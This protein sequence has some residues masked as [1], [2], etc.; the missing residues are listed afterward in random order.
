MGIADDTSLP[1]KKDTGEDKRENDGNI[2]LALLPVWGCV[3]K[4]MDGDSIWNMNMTCSAALNMF[5]EAEWRTDFP[6]LL[7]HQVRPPRDYYKTYT[8][9]RSFQPIKAKYVQAKHSFIV[10]LNQPKAGEDDESDAGVRM[11]QIHFIFEYPK[12]E[13][14]PQRGASFR[15]EAFRNT[16]ASIERWAKV[17]VEPNTPITMQMKQAITK[18]HQAFLRSKPTFP[19]C[20]WKGNEHHLMKFM[21]DYCQATLVLEDFRRRESERRAERRRRRRE[22]HRVRGIGGKM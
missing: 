15:I 2:L 4:Y 18:C 17:V 12:A 13:P 22:K 11:V 1:R 16:N 21:T 5:H 8:D 9:R 7:G 6:Y 10:L 14:K 20:S 3:E 19:Y